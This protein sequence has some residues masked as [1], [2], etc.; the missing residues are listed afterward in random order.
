[1]TRN[2]TDQSGALCLHDHDD[3]K[4]TANTTVTVT[5]CYRE[6]SDPACQ[7][8]LRISNIFCTKGFNPSSDCQ[9]LEKAQ[10]ANSPHD[11]PTQPPSCC[12]CINIYIY[13]IYIYININI[14]VYIYN[15]YNMVILT[16]HV[17]G[18]TTFLP[19]LPTIEQPGNPS[20]SPCS[21]S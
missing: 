4:N 10:Q 11:K 12:K 17:N 9:N 8:C 14:N 7:R 19:P 20:R 16:F 6:L 3:I 13:I 18:P 1:M 21:C 15:E 5:V 2:Q